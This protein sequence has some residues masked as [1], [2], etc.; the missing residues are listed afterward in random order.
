MTVSSSTA[1]AKFV[2]DNNPCDAK[3]QSSVQSA[4]VFAEDDEYSDPDISYEEEEEDST[5]DDMSLY[6]PDVDQ[7]NIGMPQYVPMIAEKIIKNS[8]THEESLG[9]STAAFNS[10]QHE[11]NQQQ[12]ELALIWIVRACSLFKLKEDESLYKAAYMLNEVLCRQDIPFNKLQLISIAC[13]WISCKVEDNVHIP[14]SSLCLICSNQFT[15][16]QIREVE[17]IIVTT[18]NCDLNPET[19]LFFIQRF[20]N[21]IDADENISSIAHFFLDVALVHHEFLDFSPT[22]IAVSA[23]CAAK[24]SLIEYCPIKRL[25]GYSHLDNNDEI[26]RCGK[27]IFQKARNIILQKS[28]PIKDRFVGNPL[29]LEDLNL[30]L[31]QFDNL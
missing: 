15:E 24:L 31:T 16:Q 22:V 1:A 4:A 21:A 11:L 17:P 12:H 6:I 3:V 26:T 2:I 20:L 30:D 10:V 28:S 5:D 18:L 29:M 25:L 27:I 19:P 9:L 14:L 13:I 8:Q 7:R 23:V